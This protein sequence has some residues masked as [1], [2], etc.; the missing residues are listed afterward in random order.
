MHFGGGG[1]VEEGAHQHQHQHQHHHQHNHQHQRPADVE[2]EEVSIFL[3]TLVEFL[4]ATSISI[5]W[6]MIRKIDLI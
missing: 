2:G 3:Y 5:L 6:L 4:N 1:D